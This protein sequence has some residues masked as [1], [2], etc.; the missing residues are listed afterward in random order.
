MRRVKCQSVV[1]FLAIKDCLAKTIRQGDNSV[2]AGRN[3]SSHCLIVGQVAQA[4]LNRLPICLRQQHFPNGSALVAACH[5]IGKVSPTFQRKIYRNLI[6]KPLDVWQVIEQSDTAK[7]DESQWGGHAGVSQATAEYLALGKF[8][9][10]ILGQHHGYAPN[11]D[12]YQ[13]NATVFGSMSWLET[14]KELINYLKNE[15]N[16]DFPEIKNEVQA[17]LVAGLTTVA[18]WI[19]SSSVFDNP[20]ENWHDKIEQALDWAG[21]IAPEVIPNL[22]FEQVFAFKP[23]DAQIKLIDVANQSGV[24]ILE[25][26]MGLGKTEAALYAAYQL[27]ATN[28]ATGIYFALPTQLTSE[29]IHERMQSFL[30][31]ILQPDSLH[32]KALLVHGNAW[33][34]QV[35]M[36]EDANPGGTWFSQGKRGVLAPFAVGT[37]DQALMAVLNV[38]HGF[39]RAFGLAGKVVILDEVHTYDAYTG[40]IMDELVD[41]LRQMDCTV[42]ILSATLTHQ[43]RAKLIQSRVTSHAYPLIT[44]TNELNKIPL[45]LV[46]EAESKKQVI[47]NVEPDDK[48]AFEVALERAAQG[49]QVLWIEN[50]VAEAQAVFKQFSARSSMLGIQTG[51]LHSRFTQLDRQKNEQRWVTRYGKEGWIERAQSGCILIGTQVLEQS[52]DIDSDFLVTRLAPTDMLL[53]RLGRLWRHD[54][55]NRN[56]EARQEAWLLAPKLSEAIAQPEKSFGSSA[57]VYAP[58]ILCRT[59]AVWQDLKNV[60]LP[61]DI[62]TLIE[63][64]YQERP[65]ID[66]MATYLQQVESTRQKL[67]NFALLGLSTVT[68]AK[69]DEQ[70]MT[71]YSEQDTLEVLLI[72]NVQQQRT[73]NSQLGTWVTLLSDEQLFLPH[74]GKALERKIWRNLAA[75]LMQNTVKVAIHNAPNA[76]SLKSLNWLKDYFYLGHPDAPTALIRVALVKDDD[77][78]KLFDGVGSVHDK[79]QLAY[80]ALQGYQA[81]K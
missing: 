56:I 18:D 68:Q 8:I 14:R 3:V 51:L 57:F 7:S 50:T 39:V 61:S 35:E 27:L 73:H 42:I 45:E 44:A 59:L 67:Q 15:L 25:A 33:L 58:Y 1:S 62:R 30:Q 9:P 36:G 5:D 70:V 29:K 75:T 20:N 63:A 21:F 55:P 64:T 2:V 78:L 13:G 37:I 24:Y 40:T 11:V 38:K 41:T 81:E 71:R 60:C 52:L 79:Y 65:E 12:M 80:N 54:N 16:Q 77:A 31:A 53:Q 26:L 69:P 6:D 49:Q 4:L 72:K 23:K 48:Q 28:K 46:V 76:Q 22:S 19:G 74:N 32:Q 10:R 47:I 17:K 43:R 34:K 66:L